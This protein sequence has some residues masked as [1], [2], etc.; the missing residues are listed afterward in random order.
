M[1]SLWHFFLLLLRVLS[2]VKAA[3]EET[4]AAHG[5]K[6]VFEVQVRVGCDDFLFSSGGFLI[7]RFFFRWLVEDGSFRQLGPDVGLL[8]GLDL[9][10]VVL[11]LQLCRL[12]LGL[13]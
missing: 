1:T 6:D 10:I 5:R 8:L 7:I 11:W 2:R 12:L 4:L 3:R 9:P 13:A